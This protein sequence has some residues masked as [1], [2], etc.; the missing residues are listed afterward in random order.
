MKKQENKIIINMHVPNRISNSMKQKLIEL[1]G[2][3]I[4]Q[5]L[6]KILNFLPSEINR[7]N[8]LKMSKL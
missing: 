1:K 2:Q 8:R 3:I 5:T 4:P 7:T 6:L